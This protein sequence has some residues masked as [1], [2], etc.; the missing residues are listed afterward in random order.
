VMVTD[1][2]FNSTGT[3]IKCIL[4]RVGFFPTSPVRGYFFVIVMKLSISNALIVI[5]VYFCRLRDTYC[6]S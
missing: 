5:G 2:G 4:L 3:G 1:S 6:M